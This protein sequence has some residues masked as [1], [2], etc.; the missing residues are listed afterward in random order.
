MSA[1][2]VDTVL[3]EIFTDK[4]PVTPHIVMSTVHKAK[5]LEADRVFI[6]RPDLMPHPLAKG[7]D[8]L[9]QEDNLHYVAITR[10]QKRLVY[11]MEDS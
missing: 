11:V 10:A 5:G 1:K 4:P 2:D 6:L 9:I 8:E 3:K 7:H